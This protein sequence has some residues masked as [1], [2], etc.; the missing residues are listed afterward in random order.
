MK[1]TV[2]LKE[3]LKLERR[4]KL[5]TFC[6]NSVVSHQYRNWNPLLANTEMLSVGYSQYIKRPV[7]GS[8][9]FIPGY[10]V[11]MPHV[12]VV[13]HLLTNTSCVPRTNPRLTLVSQHK[14]QR[15]VYF[16]YRSCFS[17]TVVTTVVA[18][19]HWVIWKTMS[20]FTKTGI[21][22]IHSLWV[23][24]NILGIK[25]PNTMPEESP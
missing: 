11:V 10:R 22:C 18:V 24:K 16:M 20:I 19:S 1:Q 6:Y 13:A 2:S 15:S 7:D 4:T 5:K 9:F 23:Y 8:I 12:L 14:L 17:K 25:I 3:Y 21:S